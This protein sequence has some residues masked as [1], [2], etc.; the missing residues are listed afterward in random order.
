MTLSEDIRAKV[1]NIMDDKF[2]TE[3]VDKVPNID[4]SRL[5]FGN[6][7]LKFKATVLHIDL[8]GSTAILNKHNKSSVAKI[9]MAYFHAIIKIVDQ[10]NGQIRSFNGD[11]ML[12]FFQGTSVEDLN[13]AVRAAMQ[14]VYIITSEDKGINN[15]LKKY[16]TIDFGIGIDYGEILCTKIGVAGVSKDL[17]WIGNAVNRA[18]KIGDNAQSPSRL[19]ISKIVYDNLE[20]ETKYS[21]KEV[22]GVKQKVDMWVQ[23]SHMYNNQQEYYY[24]TNY[25]WIIA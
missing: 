4:D 6:K 23:Q 13:N 8:R 3:E 7:G 15:Y 17:I 9:H 5:T 12:V 20:D 2:E 18:V 24:N 10:Y 14:I 1:K 11:S 22:W 19:A 21:E 16:S 25:Q